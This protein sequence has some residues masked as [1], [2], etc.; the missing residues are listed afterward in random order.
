MLYWNCSLSWKT[1]NNPRLRS[2]RCL[3]QAAEKQFLGMEISLCCLYIMRSVRGVFRAHYTASRKRMQAGC[4]GKLEQE[5]GRKQR[6][7]P[8]TCFFVLTLKLGGIPNISKGSSQSSGS[9]MARSYHTRSTSGVKRTS[10]P[11]AESARKD[12]KSLSFRERVLY[13]TFN[14]PIL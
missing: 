5:A 1:F 6:E 3:M 7:L 13:L 2:W 12:S 11:L 4:K 10:F 9:C 8:P 14:N